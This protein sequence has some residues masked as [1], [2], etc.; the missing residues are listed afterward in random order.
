MIETTVISRSV[1]GVGPEARSGLVAGLNQQLASLSDLAAAYKQAHWNVVGS[2]FS[3]LHALF[4]QFA[5]Q[6]RE[7]VDAVA[8]RVVT[9]GGTARGTIQAA[10]EQ[11]TLPPF[12]LDERCEQHLL[13][14]LVAQIDILDGDLRQAMDSTASEPATQDVYIEVVRGIE[15]QRWMLQSHLA[16]RSPSDRG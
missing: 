16:R 11:S 15:K 12:P 9:L 10:A 8:E 6:T 3:Q 13:E 14:A 4:D 5:D 2:D 1:P 7:Y